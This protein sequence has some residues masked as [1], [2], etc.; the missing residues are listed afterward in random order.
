[1]LK[2]FIHHTQ[3]LCPQCGGASIRITTTVEAFY[4]IIFDAAS[5]D[6]A[7]IDEVVGD[8]VWDERN[9]ATCPSCNW[10]GTVGD[11]VERIKQLTHS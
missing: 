8:A 10:H 5:Q 6:F 1:M 9:H 7:V 3:Q 2:D 11:L 4:D